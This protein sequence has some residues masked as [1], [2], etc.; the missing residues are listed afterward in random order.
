[1]GASPSSSFLSQSMD[2]RTIE[3]AWLHVASETQLDGPQAISMIDS[4]LSEHKAWTISQ[5][6][7]KLVPAEAFYGTLVLCTLNICVDDKGVLS[8]SHLLEDYQHIRSAVLELINRFP[9]SFMRPQQEE[10]DDVVD[11]VVCE[12]LESSLNEDAFLSFGPDVIGRPIVSAPTLL[13]DS[14]LCL[15]AFALSNGWGSIDVDQW[16]DDHLVLLAPVLAQSHALSRSLLRSSCTRNALTFLQAS[17]CR[18]SA[19]VPRTHSTFVECF[20]NIGEKLQVSGSLVAVE[21]VSHPSRDNG[22]PIV[23]I[24]TL[25]KFA[26]GHAPLLLLLNYQD[27]SGDCM[28]Y[29]ND[30]LRTDLMVC[31]MF[32]VFNAL[33]RCNS[34][35]GREIAASAL[36]FN[37]YP[38]SVSCGMME[39]VS[40][41]TS[42]RDWGDISDNIAKMTPVQL[43]EFIASAAGSFV[44]CYVLGIRDRHRDNIMVQTTTMK[45]WQVTTAIFTQSNL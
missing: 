3:D 29:K 14:T 12:P 40:E 6:A 17:Q 1:M 39:F 2:L 45:L 32:R 21:N 7:N 9:T 34:N 10:E 27:G 42:L 30:D 31:S 43:D 5:R 37:V 19:L 28:V 8:L 22:V 35:S 26:S 41:S 11:D 24:S 13:D 20:A 38:L 44:S 16:P 33:W 25:K 36:A 4:L 18:V 23:S 15:H